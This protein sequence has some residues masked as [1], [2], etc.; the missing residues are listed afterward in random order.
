MNGRNEPQVRQVKITQQKIQEVVRRAAV[1]EK[2]WVVWDSSKVA[3]QAK[4]TSK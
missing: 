2:S 3:K 1:N 4:A